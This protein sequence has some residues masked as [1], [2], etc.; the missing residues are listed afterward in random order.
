MSHRVADLSRVYAALYARIERE[1]S[2]V[3]CFRLKHATYYRAT[4]IFIAWSI[5]GIFAWFCVICV[6]GFLIQS[7]LG[8][9]EL[10][11]YSRGFFETIFMT[12]LLDLCVLRTWLVPL[13]RE[14][15]CGV[16]MLAVQ[17]NPQALL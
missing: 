17:V 6:W 16:L 10:T 13:V 9:W 5:A 14:L 8:E 15:N 2:E 11:P 3:I 12:Q 7:A 4:A 1:G